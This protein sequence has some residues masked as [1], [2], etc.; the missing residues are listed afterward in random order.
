MRVLLQQIRPLRRALRCPAALLPLLFAV[1]AGI[2]GCTVRSFHRETD[3][4]GTFRTEAASVRFLLF[5]E[6]PFEPKLRAMELARD[7][8][9]DNL[10]VTRAWS[11]PNLGFFQF[12]NGL[13]IGVRGS[14]VEGE[15]GIPPNTPEGVAAYE[16]FLKRRGT[17]RSADGTPATPLDGVDK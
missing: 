9:G 3:T 14:V 2:G 8:W 13:I 17:V 1:G 12:L 7:T 10:R 16:A 6:V 4:T 5:F 15:Y 11:W